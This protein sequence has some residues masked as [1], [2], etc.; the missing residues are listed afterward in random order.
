MDPFRASFLFFNSGVGQVSLYG[1]LIGGI[2]G[3]RLPAE[4]PGASAVYHLYVV[5]TPR[6]D[7]LREA[8]AR[9]GI[10]TGL[11]YPVPL[12]LQAA[13]E[14]LGGRR[15]LSRSARKPP[16]RYCPFPSTRNSKRSR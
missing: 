15:A 16:G 3:L 6:R 2:P 10:A 1:R 14:G 11:H 7:A 13:F 8:L 4:E 9:D 5:R 12:H